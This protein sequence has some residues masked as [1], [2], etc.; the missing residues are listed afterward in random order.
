MVDFNERFKDL[1]KKKG[2][3]QVE[4]ARITGINKDT[5]N[6]YARGIVR[7]SFEAI[8]QIAD[9]LNISADYLL[10]RGPDVRPDELHTL[11]EEDIVEQYTKTLKSKY[12]DV[13]EYLEMYNKAMGSIGKESISK[14][15]FL[16]LSSVKVPLLEDPIAAGNPIPINGVSQEYRYF[17]ADYIKKFNSPILLKVGKN[18]RSMEPTILPGDLL[19]IDRRPVE[20]LKKNRIY[21][22][23][24]PEEGGTIKRCHKDE[25][26]VLLI[27][28]NPD[29]SNHIINVADRNISELI[30][31]T[32]VWIGRELV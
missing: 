32:V 7:P 21:A 24:V 25:D 30:V 3:S 9:A 31:G 13:D 6:K 1:L 5:I 22:V 8:Q 12:D 23:N 16:N 27:P 4:L 14:E 10:G 29:Y 28:D 18:Q 20:N 15:E 17:V 11:K 2:V 19:L 26:K